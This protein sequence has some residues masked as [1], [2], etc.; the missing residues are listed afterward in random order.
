MKAASFVLPEI[1]KQFLSFILVGS[2]NTLFSYAIYAFFIFISVNYLV[3]SLV[4]FC[5]GTLVSFTTLGKMV[6]H[7]FNRKLIK[8][9]ILVYL[10]LYLTYLFVIKLMYCL[11]HSFYFSGILSSVFVVILSFIL[12]KYFIFK[13]TDRIS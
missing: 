1:R 13:Y 4:A 8:K 10:F 5:L 6:F 9:F 11:F 3:A 7:R 12:N 2:L